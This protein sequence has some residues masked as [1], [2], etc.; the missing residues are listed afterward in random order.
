VIGER[1]EA[2]REGIPIDMGSDLGWTGDFLIAWEIGWNFELY[3][4]TRL[5]GNTIQ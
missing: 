4:E 3:S 5:E 2:Y 1:V